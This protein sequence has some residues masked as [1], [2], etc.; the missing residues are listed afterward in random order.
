MSLQTT[1]NLQCTRFVPQKE[2]DAPIIFLIRQKYPYKFERGKKKK[3]TA[4]T[5]DGRGSKQ[6][7]KFWL[8]RFVH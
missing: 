2:E 7:V 5:H 4:K 3:S 6:A 8:S 1:K